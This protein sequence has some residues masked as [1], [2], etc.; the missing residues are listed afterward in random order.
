MALFGVQVRLG[1]V[2]D[3][4]FAGAGLREGDVDDGG[5]AAEFDVFDCDGYGAGLC[6][7]EEVDVQ[8]EG[9]GL[10]LLREGGVEVGFDGPLLS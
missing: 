4:F 5:L 10:V 8:G 9:V 3:D 7:A 6:A 2:A 1:Y